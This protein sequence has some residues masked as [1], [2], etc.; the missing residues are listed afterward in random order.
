MTSPAGSSQKEEFFAR[1]KGGASIAAAARQLGVHSST[2]YNWAQ[3]EKA[4]KLPERVKFAQVAR[5]SAVQV[6]ELRVSGVTVTVTRGFDPELLRQ[7][8]VALTG[9]EK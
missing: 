4:P 2:G 7:V 3:R 1:I 5:G 6:L 9:A 8:I